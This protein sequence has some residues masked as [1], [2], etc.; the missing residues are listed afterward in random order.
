MTFGIDEAIAAHAHSEALAKAKAE[1]RLVLLLDG[2]D[3]CPPERR[4]AVLEMVDGAARDG[5][6]IVLSTRPSPTNADD[7]APLG[8][9]FFEALPLSREAVAASLGEAMAE[10]VDTPLA[11]SLA[12]LALG[13]GGDAPSDRAALYSRAKVNI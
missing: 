5:A 3:E 7:L 2:L 6:V 8:F 1:R 12:T 13:R 9:R 4:A 11:L 10:F